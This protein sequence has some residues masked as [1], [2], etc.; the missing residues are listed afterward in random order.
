MAPL[1]LLGYLD[2]LFLLQR[3]GY[4][5]KVRCLAALNRFVHVPDI[6]ELHYIVPAMRL[7]EHIKCLGLLSKRREILRVMSVRDPEQYSPTVKTHVPCFQVAGARDKLIV[8]VVC[9]PS[10]CVICD[11][12]IP[13]GLQQLD[14]IRGANGGERLDGI[15]NPCLMASERHILIHNLPHPGPDGIHISRLNRRPVTFIDRAVIAFGDRPA[16]CQLAVREQIFDGF[17]QQEAKGTAIE[18]AASV[19][20]VVKELDI[21]TV[22]D[23]EPEPLSH[24]VDKGGQNVI[25]FVELKLGSYVLKVRALDKLLRGTGVLAIYLYHIQELTSKQGARSGHGILP[26]SQL[27]RNPPYG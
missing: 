27:T 12:D 7:D 20:A 25:G 26:S 2:Y 18:V 10:E 16:Y 17:I 9:C 22:I 14:L 21:K 1:N 24:I 5:D 19:G 6:A 11:I 23:L 8:V 4:L 3:L 15:L 13:A